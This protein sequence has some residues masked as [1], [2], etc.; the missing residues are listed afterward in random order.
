MSV[1]SKMTSIADKIRSLLGIS[2][3]LGLDAMDTNLETAN[4][5]VATQ[6]ELMGEIL[7]SLAGKMAGGGSGESW[8]D[9]ATSISNLFA[10]AVFDVDTLDIEYGSKITETEIGNC[11]YSAFT[12]Q[13][14]LKK[15][16]IN[17]G[18]IYINPVNCGNAFETTTS[19]GQLEKIEIPFISNVL[20]NNATRMFYEQRALKEIVGNLNLSG[21]TGAIVN[22]FQNCLAL[23]EVRFKQN[24]IPKSIDIKYSSLLSNA[25][26]Q[27]IIDGLMDLTGATAQ[28]LTLHAD[29]KAKLT[30]TQLAT[31]TGK[32]W[33]LA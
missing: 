23:E 19:Y 33:T 25:S 32:N 31:I 14:G 24:S 8:L 1:N 12:R 22:A 18:I 13:K 5:E 26:I 4:T 29:V 20:I 11:L 15:I 30:E 17:T 3:K 7:T 27:S 21:L 2:G 6:E 9:Y 28:T 16:K 10:L